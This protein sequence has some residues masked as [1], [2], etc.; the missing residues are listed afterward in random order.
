MCWLDYVRE[1]G[2]ACPNGSECYLFLLSILDYKKRTVDDGVDFLMSRC[3]VLDQVIVGMGKQGKF[4]I[5]N[6]EPEDV[7]RK[8]LG[9]LGKDFHERME[10]VEIPKELEPHAKEITRH[11]EELSEA[12]AVDDSSFENL[13]ESLLKKWRK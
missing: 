2:F 13:C 12:G 3:P 11:I 4:K 6:V 9:E 1:Q 7:I 10:K 5:E 8:Y